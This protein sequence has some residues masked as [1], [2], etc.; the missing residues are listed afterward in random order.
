MPLTAN[1]KYA[2]AALREK[3]RLTVGYKIARNLVKA[4]GLTQYDVQPSV[5][6][7]I[8]KMGLGVL[9]RPEKSG[10]RYL[11]PARVENNDM[12]IREWKAQARV[13]KVYRG[14]KYVGEVAALDMREALAV[15]VESFP[16][17]KSAK[18]VRVV[19]QGRIYRRR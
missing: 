9:H 5:A 6:F 19:A 7:G 2:L 17:L 12:D 4:R 13:W 11:I 15:A 14:D 18:S 3:G 10:P 8:E 16:K 1:Q